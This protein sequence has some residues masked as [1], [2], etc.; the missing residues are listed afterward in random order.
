MPKQQKRSKNKNIVRMETQQQKKK[1]K[2]V[3]NVQTTAE[4]N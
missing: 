3:S 2:R 1:K 4:Q